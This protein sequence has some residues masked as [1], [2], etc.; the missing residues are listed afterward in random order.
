MTAREWLDAVLPLYKRYYDIETEDVQAPF[1]A[2][3]VFKSHNEQYFLVKAAKVADIDSNEYVYFIVTD[4]VDTCKLNDF[5]RSAWDEGM[6]QVVPEY[7]HR[8]SD[9]T[10][11]ILC[12]SME[13]DVRRLVKKTCYSKSYKFG[14]YGWSNFRLVTIEAS[15]NTATYNRQG[16]QLK[17][18]IGSINKQNHIMKK[19]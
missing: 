19:E 15:S 11:Y 10:L 14:L 7:G 1:A 13:E 18:L 5:A 8:N 16:R 9:V 12:E 3:A 6:R 17:K 2:K 4:T